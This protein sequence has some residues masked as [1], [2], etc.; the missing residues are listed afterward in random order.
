MSPAAPVHNAATP[1]VDPLMS[2]PS[3]APHRRPFT[4]TAWR[5]SRRAAWWVL[6]AFAVGLGL[7]ALIWLGDRNEDDFY[8]VG[9]TPPTAATPGYEPLPTPLPAGADDTSGLEPTRESAQIEPVPADGELPRL[10][11]TAPPPPPPGP[12][13]PTEAPAPPAGALVQPRPIAGRMPAPR[14][15][16]RALRR[17]DS[18]TVLV[19][20][21]IGPD[22]VP[23]SVDVA[24]GSGSRQLDRA[25]V[26]AVERW[27]F[28]PAMRDG[29]PTVGTVV[30]PIA[31]EPNR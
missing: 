11:E 17:G 24:E 3:P 18:G 1:A 6:A 28:H 23:T 5:P 14:Y 19:R 20:A 7:F 25:A 30:V 27:R 29:R 8:R 31:F 12:P 15:P 13:A 26:D 9:D 2:T 21:E 4:L 10:V 22:G 16:A